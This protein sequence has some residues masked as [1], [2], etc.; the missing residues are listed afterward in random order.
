[1]DAEVDFPELGFTIG[2]DQ[3]LDLAA[4]YRPSMYLEGMG[5]TGTVK[6]FFY[7]NDDDVVVIIDDDD[8]VVEIGFVVNV[9]RLAPKTTMTT[10]S[11][12]GSVLD[13]GTA[14]IHQESPVH[15]Y[16]CL[17]LDQRVTGGKEGVTARRTKKGR[18]TKSWNEGK[19][20]EG[21]RRTSQVTSNRRVRRRICYGQKE[22][23][24]TRS[25]FGAA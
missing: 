12:L 19:K 21:R 4:Q 23:A 1:M 3:F 15:F 17:Q 24:G 6:I 20:D 16:D 22:R 9:V 5:P 8:V 18:R 25:V 10:S 13:D 2:A 7:F 11:S 14:K